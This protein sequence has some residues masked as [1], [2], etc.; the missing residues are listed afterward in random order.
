M[1]LTMID[2]DCYSLDENG[3]LRSISIGLTSKDGGI[4]FTSPIDGATYFAKGLTVEM[5]DAEEWFIEYGDV[6]V[7]HEILTGVAECGGGLWGAYEGATTSYSFH[8]YEGEM[9]L[10]VR[11]RGGELEKGQE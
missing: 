3:Y 11:E 6:E 4:E 1:S 7:I 2:T 5:I 9:W 8:Q 10:Y